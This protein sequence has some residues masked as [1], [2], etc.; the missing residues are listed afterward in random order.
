MRERFTVKS[1]HFKTENDIILPCVDEAQMREADRI[2]VEDFGLGILQM[3]ENAGRNLA[4]L[5]IHFLGK[6]TNKR[7]TVIAGTGGNGG[8]GLCSARHLYNHGYQVGIFLTKS[9]EAFQGAAANQLKIIQNTGIPIFP[10]KEAEG[11]VSSSDIIID[12]LIGYNLKG[13][14]RG[15]TKNYIELINQYPREIYSLDLPSGVNATT[16]ETPGVFVNAGCT[17]TLALPKIGLNNPASGKVF[18]ADIGIPP[19]VFQKIGIRIQQIFGDKYLYQ[20]FPTP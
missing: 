13:A 6:E 16:G 5:V 14:P 9:P 15:T 17:I 10:S 8:G 1:I 20:L 11:V 4:Q 7:I 18:L 12:A 3:M 19:E 2:A